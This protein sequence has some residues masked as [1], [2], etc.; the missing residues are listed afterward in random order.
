MKIG[1]IDD[2][3]NQTHPFFSPARL[4]HAGRLPEGQHA[5]HDQQGDRRARV[6]AARRP[7]TRT[8]TCRS[9]R[10]QSEHAT[11]VAGIAAGDHGTIARRRPR[12]LGRR[13]EGVP[14]QLQGADDPDRPGVGLDGNSPEIAAGIE[15]AVADGMD[16]IN[17]SLGE[18]EIEPSRDIVVK[19]I[20]GAAA[21]GVVPAVA[22]GNDF[23]GFGRGSV[24][25]PGSAPARD[26]RRRREASRCVIAYFSSGGPTPVSLQMKPDVTAPGVDV[27]S[28]VPAARARGRPERDE[29]GGAARRRRGRAPQ[30]DHP[31]WTV[32]QIKSALVLTG[33]PVY[34]GSSHA[35]ETT[36]DAG[37]RRL[38]QPAARERPAH[39]RLAD[40]ALVRPL[41]AAAPRP[42]GR[43]DSVRRGRRRRAVDGLGRPAAGR[44]AGSVRAPAAVGVPGPLPGDRARR[45]RSRARSPASSS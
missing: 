44:A 12:R 11:H 2:G 26:H 21:A 43:V 9:T 32:A 4:R 30:A 17:L 34:T 16:V 38:H 18:P 8:P 42:R 13:A 37:G 5:L 28:S 14:R 29:H 10:T 6:R 41:A 7:S 31:A 40:R 20:D 22:A 39:L 27:L 23:D 24:G 3:V 35:T 25:S 19:A 45:R 36:S 33:T 1:I 15:A